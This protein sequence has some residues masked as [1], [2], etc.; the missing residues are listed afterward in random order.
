MGGILFTHGAAF[1]ITSHHATTSSPP[2]SRFDMHP[3]PTLPTREGGTAVNRR[4]KAGV[5][6][7]RIAPRPAAAHCIGSLYRFATIRGK[8]PIPPQ[9]VNWA[10][11]KRQ[12]VLPKRPLWRGVGKVA[13]NFALVPRGISPAVRPPPR[14]AFCVRAHCWHS[15]YIAY[16]DNV[17]TPALTRRSEG[18]ADDN[19]SNNLAFAST[20]FP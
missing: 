5:F 20:V 13:G 14:F 3:S 16:I 15:A 2:L 6:E 4:E 1:C 7:Q 17:R 8:P 18:V 10:L 11:Q 19:S 9:R 12:A